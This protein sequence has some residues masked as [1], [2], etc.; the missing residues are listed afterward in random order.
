VTKQPLHLKDNVAIL[1]IW[2]FYTVHL[3]IAVL[4]LCCRW[5]CFNANLFINSQWF[6]SSILQKTVSKKNFNPQFKFMSINLI[7]YEQAIITLTLPQ[8]KKNWDIPPT[9]KSSSINKSMRTGKSTERKG[10]RACSWLASLPLQICFIVVD[11][12][13]CL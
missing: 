10:T 12:L 3:S 1:W 6:S 8:H 9:P 4:Q 13:F 5:F 11:L 7:F 2:W